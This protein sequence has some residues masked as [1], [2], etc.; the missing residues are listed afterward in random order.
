[1]RQEKIPY[2]HGFVINVFIIH[3]L[4][5]R[6]SNISFIIENGLFGN[7]TIVPDTTGNSNYK[8]SGYGICFDSHDK[9]CIGNIVDGKNE[10][11]L[12]CI[13]LDSSAHNSNKTSV[14]GNT[15]YILGPKISPAQGLNGKK[16]QL[17]GVYKTNFTQ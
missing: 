2:S 16:L 8:Y 5:K 14:S 13:I 15:V 7:L 3:K 6:D 4:A 10:F 12:S 17:E 9:T 1:M 11:I